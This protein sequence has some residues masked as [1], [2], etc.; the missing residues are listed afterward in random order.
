MT[1]LDQY[2]AYYYDRDGALSLPVLRVRYRDP[3]QTWLYFDP[4]RG[5]IARKAGGTCG[6]TVFQ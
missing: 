6:T 4:K 2:D 5:T 3:Q 1:W